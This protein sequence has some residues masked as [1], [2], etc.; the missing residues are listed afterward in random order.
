[1]KT[2]KLR[3]ALKLF[4]CKDLQEKQFVSNS[5]NEW[6]EFVGKN[7]YLIALESHPPNLQG[8]MVAQTKV[9]NKE[10]LLTTLKLLLSP[11]FSACS[12]T[13]VSFAKNFLIP[14]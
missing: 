6:N 14:L 9:G 7:D 8:A 2:L 13:F 3:R 1:M 10:E 5:D 12:L 11:Q 4:I